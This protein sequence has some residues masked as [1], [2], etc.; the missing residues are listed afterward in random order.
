MA[1]DLALPAL[2][3]TDAGRHSLHTLHTAFV[4]QL[5]VGPAQAHVTQR[6][7]MICKLLGA[8]RYASLLAHKLHLNAAHMLHLNA[9][10]K[11]LS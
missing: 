2:R 8:L 11:L 6:S 3:A 5:V 4:A 10:H 7:R 1:H 9:A